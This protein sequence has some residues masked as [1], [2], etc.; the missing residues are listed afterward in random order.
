MRILLTGA[1][2]FVGRHLLPELASDHEVVA[3]TRAPPPSALAPLCDWVEADLSEPLRREALPQQV[4]A[5]IH[6]AQSEHYKAFPDGADDV[7]AVNVAATQQLVEYAVAAGA[8]HVVFTSTGGVYGHS[9]ER[10]SETA[11]VSPLDFYLSSKLA[12]ELLIGNYRSLVNVVVFRPFFVYGAGQENMLVPR[13]ARRVID[14]ERIEIQGDPGLRINPLHVRDAAR[15]FAPALARDDSGLFN[16]AGDEAVTLTDLVRRLG[17]A[18][19]REPVIAHT[20]NDGG[21][22]LVGDNRLMREVLGVVPEVSLDAGLA[23]VVRALT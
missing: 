16:I 15:T 7:F 11:P 17:A 21:G 18:A 10:L 5:V 14:G 2:G 20:P 19:G 6:L 12:A 4:D 3:L 1:T 9:D 8:S 22:D 23:D 13:L